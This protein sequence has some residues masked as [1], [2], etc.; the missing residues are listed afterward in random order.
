MIGN[1]FLFCPHP[2]LTQLYIL[3]QFIAHTWLEDQREKGK[4]ELLNSHGYCG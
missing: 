3:P 4:D 2:L 1:L